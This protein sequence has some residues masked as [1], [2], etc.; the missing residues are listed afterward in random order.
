MK[1]CWCTLAGTK[2][3]RYCSNSNDFSN[4]SIFIITKNPDIIPKPI[5]TKTYTFTT[6]RK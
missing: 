5:T 4:E 1:A 2:A 6:W 3:C